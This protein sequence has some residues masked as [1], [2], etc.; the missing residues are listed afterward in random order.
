MCAFELISV[1]RVY[2]MLAAALR[3]IHTQINRGQRAAFKCI[4]L[5]I[6]V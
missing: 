6:N 1:R 5:T 3:I 4:Q 2:M